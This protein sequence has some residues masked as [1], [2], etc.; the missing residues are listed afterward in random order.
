MNKSLDVVIIG[1]GTAGYRPCAS[2]AVRPTTS[3]SSTTVLR[4]DLR[5]VGCMPSKAL[6]EAANAFH[7]R[8]AFGNFGI[9]GAE[10]LTVD[11]PAVLRHVRSLRDR[12]VG[13]TVTVTNELGPR[14]IA[15]QARFVAPDAVEVN[16]ERLQAR[17]IIIATGSRPIVP[18]AWRAFG[19]RI[20]T[21][22][23]LFEL[24]SFPSR[25]AVI[26]MGGVGVEI[27]QALARLGVVVV[28][29]GRS[30]FVAGL[31]DP[32][33]NEKA[34]E[35]LRNEFSLHLGVAPVVT[36][37]DDALHVQTATSRERVD[38]V[39]AALGRRPNIDDLG[40][41]NLALPSIN[42]A[43]RRSIRIRCKSRTCR[44]SSPA[45]QQ[46]ACSCF[47][48]RATK[49]TLRGTTRRK[50]RRTACRDAY[51]LAIVF[52]DPN[53]AIV[54]VRFAE[55][56]KDKIIVGAV[57][58]GDQG[59]SRMAADNFGTLR[60]YAG[61][62][63]GSLARLRI[64]RAARRTFCTSIGAGDRPAVNCRQ[65]LRMPFYHPVFEEGLRTALRD[66]AAQLPPGPH[67]ELSACEPIGAAALE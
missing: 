9:N 61:K 17:K 20:L 44:S 55:L 6:I 46:A 26:G 36:A 30:A 14:S 18:S 15:G 27:A 67:G 13:G 51:R 41:E 58:F 19:K 29:Y 23:D 64:I 59:R 57:D 63:D 3:S 11:I 8:G 52:T 31:T 60:L 37:H 24:D 22:D 47:T 25:M 42:T 40:L 10:K 53:I 56:D 43:R 12:F 39:F 32:R 21:S 48:R 1:A 28:G 38:A 62:A 7:R 2:C 66:L 49:G 35:L 4:H 33:V 34:V 65:L 5:G 45:M 16:G 50:R 54:G